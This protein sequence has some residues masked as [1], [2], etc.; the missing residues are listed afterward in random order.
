MHIAILL[1]TYNGASYLQEQLNSFIN[2]S[3]SNW[4]LWVSDDGSV[5]S[6]LDIIQTFAIQL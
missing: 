2:Q 6:T 3:H 1:G 5:D 4:S